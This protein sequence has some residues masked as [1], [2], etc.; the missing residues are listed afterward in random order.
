[1]LTGVAAAV[2]LMATAVFFMYLTASTYWA[3]ILDTVETRRVGG[4]SGFVHMI[5][6]CAGI[7]APSVTGYLVKWSGSFTSAFIVTGG[8]AVAGALAVA[9]F[10]KAPAVLGVPGGTGLGRAPNA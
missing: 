8:I 7:V 2:T 6:N 5:A 4:V 9:V 1:M 10:V 3:I